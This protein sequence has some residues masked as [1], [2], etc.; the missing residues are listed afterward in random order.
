MPWVLGVDGG[1]N[2]TIALVA[3]E[4]GKV[5]GRGEA[6]PA[7]Y[8]TS[9][10]GR[11]VEA[12]RMATQGAIADSGLV[13]QA[14]AACFFAV[15]G[16]D[17]PVDRQVMASALAGLDLGGRVLLDH[18]AAAT[19]AGATG[20]RPGA[21]VIAGTGSIA[22]AENEQ[23]ATARAGGYGPVLG[24]EGS[25]YD[26]GRRALL[27]AI[28]HEDGRGPAT[29]LT[30]LLKDRFMLDNMLDLTHL[31]HGEPPALGRAEISHLAPLVIQTAQSGD[32]VTKEILR[33]A[34]RELGI[35]G[36]SVLSQLPF[37]GPEVPVAGS[38]DVFGAGN[39]L[40]LP[41]QQ[42]LRSTCPGAVLIAP[43]HTPA[44]GATLLALRAVGIHLQDTLPGEGNHA[45]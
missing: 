30:Q 38:G 5:L 27:A 45:G 20:N 24:D 11:A 33:I 12:I 43:R 17:R 40:T 44:Y 37:A 41:M 23:G 1:G 34:G 29:A 14:L 8:H 2:K 3:N 39:I 16:V 13:P 4:K 10:L 7:N 36:A 22:Y 35:A 9:G 32:A 15:A 19:L 21:V 25:A 28:R 6:G 18:N 31:V 42:V 26:I